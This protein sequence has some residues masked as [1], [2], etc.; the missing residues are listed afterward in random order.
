MS[1]VDRT[2]VRSS[3]FGTL[4]ERFWAKVQKLEDGCWLWTG[5]KRGCG[6][7]TIRRNGKNTSAHVVAY[8]MLVGPIPDGLEIDHLCRVRL[9]VNPEHMEPVTHRENIRRS[10]GNFGDKA[11]QTECI[12]GH[13]LSGDNLYIATN[14]RRQCRACAARRQ[15]EFH[16]RRAAA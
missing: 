1:Q 4:E 6:Y 14:G 10:I 11:R 15:R 7:G 8:E 16:A 9:C 3:R 12:H 2:P 13:P 5:G